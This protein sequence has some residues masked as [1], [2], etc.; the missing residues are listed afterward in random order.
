M[1]QFARKRNARLDPSAAAFAEAA[2][3]QQPHYFF[4]QNPDGT[5]T[6]HF[7]IPPAEY[8]QACHGLP[9]RE[10]FR[11]ACG[12]GLRSSC[13]AIISPVSGFSSIHSVAF[14][15]SFDCGNP[16]VNSFAPVGRFR[17]GFNSSPGGQLVKGWRWSLMIVCGYNHSFEMINHHAAGMILQNAC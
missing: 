3:A 7:G 4:I 1:F 5:R 9:S 14:P 12:S 6:Q 15:G 16:L 17:C 11:C 8:Q 13:W 2:P 10:F